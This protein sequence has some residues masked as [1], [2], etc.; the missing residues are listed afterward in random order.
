MSV[1]YA[2]NQTLCLHLFFAFAVFIYVT[3]LKIFVQKHETVYKMNDNLANFIYRYHIF[4]ILKCQNLLS[5]IDVINFYSHFTWMFV[6]I[7]TT[8][9][10]NK[11]IYYNIHVTFNMLKSFSILDVIF[12][13]YIFCNFFRSE[14]GN[15]TNRKHTHS[16]SQLHVWTHLKTNSRF[17]AAFHGSNLDGEICVPFNYE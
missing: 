17:R 9:E 8:V 3:V 15:W 1:T 16:H 10:I 5:V 2:I 4:C 6:L 13:N 7:C 14:C 11:I 12:L